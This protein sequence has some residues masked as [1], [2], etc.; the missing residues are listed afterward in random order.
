MKRS[1]ILLI[2]LLVV[3]IVAP[4]I[5]ISVVIS[6]LPSFKDWVVEAVETLDSGQENLYEYKMLVTASQ[7]IP[8][9]YMNITT[10]KGKVDSLHSVNFVAPAEGV[11]AELRGDSIIVNLDNLKSFDG[12]G[13][14]LTVELPE[15]NKLKID[16]S[17]STVDI[18]FKGVDLGAVYAATYGDILVD[19]SNL[20]ALM[21]AENDKKKSI[22]ISDSNIGAVKFFGK[23]TTLYVDNS[24]NGAMSIGGT[25][26]AITLRDSSIGVVSWNN[27]CN[28]KAV[29]EDCEV[30]I[31]V[32]ENVLDVNYNE[33]VDDDSA[34]IYIIGE[35]G[36][37]INMT[38][39]NF[40]IDTNDGE[41]VDIS[42]AGLHVKSDDGEK[43]DIS[44][45]GVYVDDG[46][47]TVKITPTGVV[48]KENGE[49]I[50]NVGAN[51]VRVK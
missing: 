47:T 3:V 1:T 8:D 45:N 32:K 11:K 36:E 49:E 35:D 18:R 34:T 40:Q 33:L 48:V 12:D 14:F 50:V 5:Y 4:I 28:D 6:K 46:E 19:D 17:V 42:P 26:D 23:S 13:L 22:R 15:N 51:G 27:E 2:T 41:R 21:T 43:V 29:I 31:K 7:P 44:I 25:C 38:S 30:T 9:C 37:K 39:G 16:N 20:G 24:N 10:Y